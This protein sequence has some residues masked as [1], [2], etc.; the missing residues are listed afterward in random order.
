MT[1][2]IEEGVP[3]ETVNPQGYKGV[4][5]SG[6][7]HCVRYNKKF[8]EEQLNL[9]HFRLDYFGYEEAPAGQSALY[10]SKTVGES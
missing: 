10:I 9:N 4:T 7:L 2:Y 1:A 8:F 5:W 3:D 6:I